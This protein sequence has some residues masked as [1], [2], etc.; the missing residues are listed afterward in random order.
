MVE[1]P[2]VNDGIS[3]I[4]PQL[5]SRISESST[6]VGPYFV[7]FVPSSGMNSGQLGVFGY[8]LYMGE[9]YTTQLYLG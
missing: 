8:L 9:Y 6:V 5:V 7:F 3:T 2:V 4:Q 1:K